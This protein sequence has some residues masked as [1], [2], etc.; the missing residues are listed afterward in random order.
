MIHAAPL[1]PAPIL[2]AILAIA[3]LTACDNQSAAKPQE[4]PPLPV[5]VASPLVKRIAEWDEYTGRFEAVE[6]VEVRAR[7]SGYLQS[8]HFRD[9]QNVDAG[10]LLFVIDSRPFEAAVERA[11]AE[12][13]RAS[14]R[15]DLTKTELARYEKLIGSS[16]VSQEAYDVRRQN[17]RDAEAQLA[18]ARAT[19]RAAE[20]DL[21]FTQIK[22]PI[23]GRI[24]NKRVDV[25]N[26]VS[27]GSPESTLLTTIVALDPIHFVFDMSE[28]D[29]LRHSRRAHNGQRPATRE[30][31]SPVYVRLADEMEWKRQ[32]RMNFLDNVVNPASGTIRGRAVMDNPDM[33]L[34]P[35]VFG[36]IRVV[37][38][39]E[40]DAMLVPDDAVV[41]DQT[42]RVLLVVKEDGTVEPRPVILGPIVDGLRVVRSGVSPA[43][44]VIIGGVQRARPGAKVAPQPGEIQAAAN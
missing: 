9:G 27:G 1:R 7:V 10:Q 21:G 25:G 14:T 42:R 5:V 17:A 4:P 44:K 31:E 41:A 2:A 8:V 40:Y 38:S 43:D 22:S 33:F 32:G 15:V 36:R 19:L 20:L 11:K 28:A 26:V 3:V 6:M 30:S 23:R 16:T 24:S 39:A 29:F 37:G 18:S 12:V 34:T 13:Q 35:G